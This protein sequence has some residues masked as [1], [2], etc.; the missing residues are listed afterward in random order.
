MSDKSNIIIKD[1]KK[2]SSISY[3]LSEYMCLKSLIMLDM[4]DNFSEWLISNLKNKGWSQAE[5]ARRAGTSRT[6]IS[7][8]ISGKNPAG[9]EVC[10][11]IANAFGLPPEEVFRAAN[12]LPPAPANTERINRLTHL[13]SMLGE[14]DLQDL[15]DLARAKIERTKK[16]RIKPPAQTLLKR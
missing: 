2:L 4:N 11:G 15:E 10:L 6:A 12:L 16:S 3:E 1:Y 5:L 13:L 8:A 9:F 14:D 7:D